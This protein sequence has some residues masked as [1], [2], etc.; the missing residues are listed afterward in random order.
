MGQQSNAACGLV[1]FIPTFCA[2]LFMLNSTMHIVAKILNCFIVV[3]FIILKLCCFILVDVCTHRKKY[4]S[5]YTLHLFCNPHPTAMH[6]VLASSKPLFY[7]INHIGATRFKIV[8]VIAIIIY[9]KCKTSS[10]CR[11]IKTITSFY[12]CLG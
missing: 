12:C 11:I 4:L 6:L 7:T 9:S 2:I 5:N 1:L 10:S 3:C 8:K